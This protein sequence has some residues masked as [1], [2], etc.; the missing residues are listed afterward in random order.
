MIHI[1][2]SRAY[3][4]GMGQ[5]GRRLAG[6]LSRAGV[7]AI[8]VTRTRGWDEVRGDDQGA[9][10]VCVREESLAEVLDT[11]HN[12]P[13]ERLV[14]V[15]NGWIRPLIHD[16]PDVTRGLIWFTSKNEFFQILRPNPFSGRLAGDLA[17]A[18]AAGG[19]P[20]E[21]VDHETFDRLDAD[22]MG[23]NCVVGLPL[24]FHGLTL[25][26]YMDDHASEARAVFDEAVA[27]CSA[28]AGATPRPDGWDALCESAGHLGWLRV[29]AA[30]ALDFRNGA[31]VALAASL[32]SS[33]PVN[34]ELLQLYAEKCA[35]NPE[36]DHLS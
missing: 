24:A 3:V 28:A 32:G 34:A 5:V 20:S 16:L 36:R 6:A 1:A 23:F 25:A 18:L 13:S 2:L 8:P 7:Q 35:T 14:L 21:A 27:A 17:L 11:L 12:L 15:Q 30:K 19:L 22:K 31:V 9:C 26:E 4:V 33:A 29:A 10:I